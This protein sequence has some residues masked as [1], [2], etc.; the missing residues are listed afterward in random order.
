MALVVENGIVAGQKA[1]LSALNDHITN[2]VAGWSVNQLTTYE[3]DP[4][5]DPGVNEDWLVLRMGTEFYFHLESFIRSDRPRLKLGGSSAVDGSD[6][7]FGGHTDQ[8]P[9]YSKDVQFISMSLPKTDNIEYWFHSDDNYLWISCLMSSGYW[10]HAFLGKPNLFAGTNNGFIVAGGVPRYGDSDANYDF[11]N[12]TL[13]GDNIYSVNPV[14]PVSLVSG[15]SQGSYYCFSHAGNWVE[16]CDDFQT[17]N[18]IGYISTNHSGSTAPSAGPGNFSV[19]MPP[20]QVHAT[21]IVATLNPVMLFMPH[22]TLT[23]RMAP[24]GNFPGAFYVWNENIA[25]QQVL[26][27]GTDDYIVFPAMKTRRVVHRLQYAGIAIKTP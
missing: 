1:L 16:V 11:D 14:G 20:F 5:F 18:A 2:D 9:Q 26:T 15:S 8:N 7:I 22:S 13:S 6:G 4:V 23:G 25:E 17:S 27:I 10:Q 19:F 12:T 3:A 24:Y 21:N